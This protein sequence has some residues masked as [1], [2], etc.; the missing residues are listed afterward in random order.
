[1][2]RRIDTTQAAAQRQWQSLTITL[3]QW[4]HLNNVVSCYGVTFFQV[5]RCFRKRVGVW[6]GFS[7]YR[8]LES[9]VVVWLDVILRSEC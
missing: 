1:M 3:V 4:R 7:V 8:L 6:F 5:C 9:I 2:S